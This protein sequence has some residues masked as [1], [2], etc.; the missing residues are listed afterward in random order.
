MAVS[1]EQ[2]K[3]TQSEYWVNEGERY[4]GQSDKS[5]KSTQDALKYIEKAI[6]INPL[7]FHAWADKGFLLKQLGE[8]DSALM[9]LNRSI[10]LKNDYFTPWYN[11]GVILGLLGKFNEAVDCYNEVLKLVPDHPYAKRDRD[12]LMGLA[13]RK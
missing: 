5:S 13:K 3:D 7:N 8:M 11:K 9:C 1:S 10:A 12:V 2:S 4:W 6:S